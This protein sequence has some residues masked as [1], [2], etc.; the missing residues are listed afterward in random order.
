MSSELVASSSTEDDSLIRSLKAALQANGIQVPDEKTPVKTLLDNKDWIY[1]SERVADLRK[2]L[3]EE[4]LYSVFNY[5]HHLQS[6]TLLFDFIKNQDSC[7]VYGHKTQGKT[8]F[9]FFVFQ[10]LQAMGEKVLFLDNTMIP[11]EEGDDKIAI[12]KGTF[13]GKWWKDSFLQIDDDTVKTC[14][15]QFYQDALPSSFG[16]FV[17]A[18]RTFIDKGEKKTRIWIIIDEVVLFEKVKYL[19]CLPKEQDMG[20]FNWIITGSAGIG[21]W[22][23]KRHLEKF[24]FDLPLFTKDESLTFAS[25]L[26]NN[27]NIVLEDELG[28]PSA[29]IDDWLEERFGGVV[30]YIAEMCL[31]ISQ[32]NTVSQYISVLNRRIKRVIMTVAERRNITEEQVASIWLK[33]ILS[34][35]NDWDCLRDAGLCGS[36]SPRGVIFASIL[37]SLHMF[38]PEVDALALVSRFRSRF[39]GDPGLDGCLLE[40]E[41]ILKLRAGCSMS[42]SLLKLR[43]QIWNATES[44]DLP[45]KGAAFPLNVM[46]FDEKCSMLVDT[47]KS[48]ESSWSLIQVPYGFHLIDV[49]LVDTTA[50][51]PA[52]YGIQ[53]TRSPE[54]FKGHDTFDTC[55][56]QSREKL[57]NLWRVISTYFELD[58]ATVKKFY[59]MVA[60]N[61]KKVEYK[62]PVGHS[63]DYYFSPTSVITFPAAAREGK[64]SM[65]KEES[66][67]L[68]EN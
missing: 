32:G 25:R 59:V 57:E 31:E 42:A 65:P 63:S 46:T 15:D 34:P 7:V 48:K 61:C 68:E 12:G 36:S 60:P 17:T 53:I 58:A 23:G 64:I 1:P 44:I 41:E 38:Y 55:R 26:C 62:P 13:C 28:V 27:L 21:S 54:P 30:G 51:S 11:P 9:L 35:N 50:G 39:A 43:D 33:E 3:N 16:K 22:V 37:T 40:L 24:V 6:A 47:V 18:L 45:T 10:L 19:I 5:Q 67:K 29:G 56:P 52:I 20:P 14:L 4:Q 2:K 66:S 49:V 8:Q